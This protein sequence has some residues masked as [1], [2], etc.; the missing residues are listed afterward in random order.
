MG[1]RCLFMGR[2]C[3]CAHASPL[4]R[5]MLPVR[6]SCHRYVWNTLLYFQYGVYRHFILSMIITLSWAGVLSARRAVRLPMSV[7]CT[8]GLLVGLLTMVF[9]SPTRLT[10]A[11]DL[12]LPPH[13]SRTHVIGYGHV[14]PSSHLPALST[15]V[16]F[17]HPFMLVGTKPNSGS[18]QDLSM[19][20]TTRSHAVS[21]GEPPPERCSALGVST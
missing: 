13:A 11:G 4:L 18:R 2:T 19:R 15:L 5:R 17:G 1:P 10:S 3:V 20:R 7:G 16:G 9:I 12:Y 6:N 8:S 14:V 21:V